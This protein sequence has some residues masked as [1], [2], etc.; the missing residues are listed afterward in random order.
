MAVTRQPQ[1]LSGYETDWSSG[2]C[3]CCDDMSE[4]CCAFWCCPCFACRTSKRHGQCLC[5]PLLDV[6]GCICPIT[7]SM[8]VSVRQR[9]GIKGSL[10]RDCV[11]SNFCLPCVWCQMSREMKEVK[12]PTMLGDIIYR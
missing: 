1:A 12:L 4:C 2:I 9:Y 10:L 8:R 6:C 11:C 7:M 3:D 5:L